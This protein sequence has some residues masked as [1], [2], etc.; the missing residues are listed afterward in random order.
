MSRERIRK[1]IQRLFG[2]GN[3]NR[4]AAMVSVLI[5]VAFIAVLATSL[6]YLSYMNYLTKVMRYGS[7]DDF[8]TSEYAVDE[9]SS[10][11][12]QVAVD[13]GVA[14]GNIS[15]AISTITAKV[16]G[17]DGT[18]DNDKVEALLRAA[19]HDASIS[20]N[21]AVTGVDNYTTT[22]NSVTLKGV[23]V[24][25]TTPQGYV[26]TIRT[27]IIINFRP[28]GEG[29]LDINDF[30]VISDSP[31]R[32]GGQA[33]DLILSG[34]IYAQKNSAAASGLGVAS[35]TA[36]QLDDGA[37]VSM[38]GDKAVI[39]GDLVVG[40]GCTLVISTDTV[41]YGDVKIG[42][43]STV[44]MLDKFK[45][46]GSISGSGKYK[47]QDASKL[48][49]GYVYDG[50][51]IPGYG[52]SPKYTGLVN[53]LF[54]SEVYFYDKS[55]NNWKAFDFE[56]Y[57]QDGTQKDSNCYDVSNGS[58]IG[59][60]SSTGGPYVQINLSDAAHNFNNTLVLGTN[61]VTKTHYGAKVNTTFTSTK[62]V[63][64]N[65]ESGSGDASVMQRMKDEDYQK[66]LDSCFAM[67]FGNSV[68]CTTED[69]TYDYNSHNAQADFA[70]ATDSKFRDIRDSDS[71]ESG[72]KIKEVGDRKYVYWNGNN[73]LPVRYLLDDNTRQMIDNIF[74]ASSDT[75]DPTTSFVEYENWVKN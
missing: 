7:T 3:N 15:D 19:T 1:K 74:S 23:Q 43:N 6:L 28:Q 2:E 65:S 70:W 14:G 10:T 5:A 16:G 35:G 11:L 31:V 12:Q 50:D 73:Y 57:C 41:V 55:V 51:E 64:F 62:G 29:S 60:G 72:R 47:T 4:G 24:T 48:K 20:V 52:A 53:R 40:K 44:I 37:V 68:P 67:P 45:V 34:C 56:S 63:Y 21:S 42:Q 54:C 22:S 61:R 26:S 58:S 32:C 59:D 33:G 9:L 69:G 36:F 46:T 27:D 39:N 17:G 66:V 49:I 18:Y 38:I 8:Y 25:S 13:K 71:Y 30:S 75:S